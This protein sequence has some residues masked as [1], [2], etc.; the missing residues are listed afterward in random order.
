MACFLAWPLLPFGVAVKLLDRLE[1]GVR[2]A[3]GEPHVKACP[4][5]G[6]LSL[7]GDVPGLGILVR[8]AL[9]FA[10]A[11]AGASVPFVEVT[12]QRTERRGAY[13]RDFVL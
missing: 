5:S 2:S 11:S 7:T 10:P 1:V 4:G 8:S 12:I 9:G 13:E 6:R 3:V